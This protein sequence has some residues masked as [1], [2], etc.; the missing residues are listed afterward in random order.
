MRLGCRAFLWCVLWAFLPAEAQA[1]QLKSYANHQVVAVRL[2]N[3]ADVQRLMALEAASDDFDVWSEGVGVG[4]VEV[5]VSPAQRAALDASGLTY[6]ILIPDVQALVT[7]ERSGAPGFFDDFRTYSE[8]VAFMNNLVAQFPQLASMVNFGT[9]VE[10]RPMWGIRVSSPGANKPGILIHGCEHA[11]E[12]L[13]PPTVAYLAEQL[14]VN[15]GSD[16]YATLLLDSV[17]WYLLPVMNPDGYEYTWTTDRFWRKNRRGGYGVDLNRN[18]GYFWGGVG[19]SGSQNSDLFRGPSAFSEPETTALRDFILARP[20]IRGHVDLHT[21]GT[22]L[23]WPWGHTNALPPQQ[24]TLLSVG[25]VMRDFAATVHGL[26]YTMGPVYSTIYPA[27]GVSVDW[28]HGVA[29]RWSFT[30]ELRGSGFAVPANQI[31]LSAE[32]NLPALQYFG[33]WLAACDPQGS[34]STASLFPDCD[35]DSIADLCEMVTAGIDDCNDNDVPDYCDTDCNGNAIPD[36]CDL[37]AGTSPD[38]DGNVVPDE[39]DL[40]GDGDSLIDACD[41]CPLVSNLSQLDG[42][43]D[44]KGDVCDPCPL[45]FSDDADGDGA[46]NSNEQCPFDPNKQSPGVCGC[47]ESDGDADGDAV[48]DCVDQ[49]PGLDDALYAPGCVN[50]IPTVST[51]GLVAMALMLMVVAKVGIGRRAARN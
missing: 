6:R 47:G 3:D 44:G 41:N 1:Q 27:S 34:G 42:D 45:D 30:F 31:I 20:N 11:R 21:Y 7:A 13:T 10:G 37:T 29:G 33:G 16:D 5:R 19:S 15:Y 22:L 40:D 49:C 25:T 36:D 48:A 2:T 46:C 17:E 24:S 4:L 8:H 32:E 26:F 23:M 14:L 51:W 28:V 50:A 18:W 9:T 38:C 12:W 35:G 43:L 39:C